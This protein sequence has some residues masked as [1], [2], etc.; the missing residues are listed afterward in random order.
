MDRMG[1]GQEGAERTHGTAKR[2]AALLVENRV[3]VLVLVCLAVFMLLLAEVLEGELM[4]IDA[5]ARWLIVEHLRADWLTPIMEAFS[6]LATPM[7]IVAML[8]V[9]AAFAPGKR[10]GWCCAL[11]VGLVALLNLGIK[12]L[13]QRPRPEGIN[14]VVEHGFSFPSGHSMAA[15]AFFGLLVWLVWHY[16]DDRRRRMLFSA[17]FSLIILMIGISR[18]YLGVHYAS[19]VIGGFCASLIW[20]AFYTR[21][22]VPLFLG[23]TPTR[24]KV[25]RSARGE[26][27]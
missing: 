25:E 15:C 20:L 7:V 4:R 2:L 5:L 19:D 11:N 22:A 6:A 14:L 8:L 17:V 1:S 13:V 3:L 12:A 27:P 24:R 16:E 23:P 21:I 10:P 18:I 9:I 26:R